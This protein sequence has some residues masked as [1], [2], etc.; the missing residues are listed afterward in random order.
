MFLHGFLFTNSMIEKQNVH[1]HVCTG[2]HC[3]ILHTCISFF[4]LY[5]LSSLLMD[6]NNSN[7]KKIPTKLTT[8]FPLFCCA[9]VCAQW[10][11]GTLW[12]C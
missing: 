12:I 9:G 7:N 8:L 6:A 11:T 4:G 1:V 5:H 2:L 10:E 3:S